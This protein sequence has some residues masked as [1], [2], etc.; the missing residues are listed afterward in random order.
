MKG[1][2]ELS[3]EVVTHVYDCAT[4]GRFAA[5]PEVQALMA[6]MTD[7]VRWN[8]MARLEVR[9]LP[10]SADGT[11]VLEPGHFKPPR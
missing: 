5:G 10:A 9:A 3:G 7:A 2:A 11:V 8:V 1:H 6:T 4:C